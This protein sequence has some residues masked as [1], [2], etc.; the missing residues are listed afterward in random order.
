[1]VDL[2][3]F[4]PGISP[5]SQRLCCSS[6]C[7]PL[8]PWWGILLRRPLKNGELPSDGE[9][10]NYYRATEEATLSQSL[11]TSGEYTPLVYGLE[12]VDR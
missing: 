12:L 3:S 9:N 11:I 4:S 8:L 6:L 2:A 7:C 10:T 1:M 5:L